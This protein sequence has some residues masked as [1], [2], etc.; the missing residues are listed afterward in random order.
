MGDK[1]EGWL[2]RVGEDPAALSSVKRAATVPSDVWRPKYKFTR[3]EFTKIKRKKKRFFFKINL[4][5]KSDCVFKP[6][7]RILHASCIIWSR[8]CLRHFALRFWNHTWLSKNHSVSKKKKLYGFISTKI[9]HFFDKKKSNNI[10]YS[11]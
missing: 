2:E 10:W 11:K 5:N 6:I 8:A 7:Q 3:L 4:P 9:A 1:T